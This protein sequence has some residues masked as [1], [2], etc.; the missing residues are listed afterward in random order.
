MLRNN[1]FDLR[2]PTST[3]RDSK[4]KLKSHV[5]KPQTSTSKQAS[6]RKAHPEISGENSISSRA[7]FGA[8]AGHFVNSFEE[9]GTSMLISMESSIMVENKGDMLQEHFDLKELGLLP[10][11][12]GGG[13]GPA[14][15]SSITD[16]SAVQEK[17]ASTHENSDTRFCQP[18]VQNDTKIDLVGE[19][20]TQVRENGTDNKG[21]GTTLIAA[22][23][24]TGAEN[25]VIENPK[26]QDSP[27]RSPGQ[28]LQ[29]ESNQQEEEKIKIQSPAIQEEELTTGANDEK[30][31][32]Q[33][34]LEECKQLTYEESLEAK[35]G[36]IFEK[37]QVNCARYY[38]LPKW[39]S[40]RTA[41]R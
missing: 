26:Q 10:K 27:N 16:S 29:T 39:L 33:K 9:K 11:E 5:G 2:C 6:G 32:E 41:L 18:V 15:L 36:N 13:E 24:E 12:C 31:T 14:S 23:N 19:E 37:A 1:S 7:H 8:G 22:N 40:F 30:T 21:E 17:T 3:A 20:K 35:I 34:P 4:E 38:F 28:H 25:L